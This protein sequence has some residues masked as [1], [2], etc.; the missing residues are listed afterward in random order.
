MS[1]YVGVPADLYRDIVEHFEREEKLALRL[2]NSGVVSF[3][4]ELERNGEPRST[5]YTRERAMDIAGATYRIGKGGWKYADVVVKLIPDVEFSFRDV[6]ERVEPRISVKGARPRD[7]M[8]IASSI[9]IRAL[10]ESKT[11]MNYGIAASISMKTTP[12][13]RLTPPRGP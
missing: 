3:S 9:A 10:S 11:A 13:R 1:K 8:R 6:Y 12:P 2:K 7:S 4:F 5:V